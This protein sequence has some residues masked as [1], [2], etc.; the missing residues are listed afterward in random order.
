MSDEEYEAGFLEVFEKAV[1]DRLR[2][3]TGTCGSMLSGG[4]DSGSVV[5]VA[6][7]ILDANGQ[8]R[9]PT[10][11]TAQRPDVDCAESRAIH[12]AVTMPAISPTIIYPDELDNLQEAIASEYDEPFDASSSML[13]AIY[14]TARSHGHRVLLDGG[15]GDLV[16]NDGSYIN[17]LIRQRQVRQAL[18][19]IKGES[20]FWYGASHRRNLVQHFRAA[21]VPFA[22]KRWFQPAR[23]RAY[24]RRSIKESL[25]SR[26]FA[27]HV[28]IPQR[29]A[30]YWDLHARISSENPAVE[31]CDKIL[32]NALAGRERYARLA[33]GADIEARDPFLDRR[34]VEYC[35]RLPGRMLIK[36]GWPKAI[37]RDLMKDRLPDAVRTCRGKPHVGWV[38]NKLVTQ[39]ACDRGELDPAM[40][41]NIL[42]D[43][44][45]PIALD[46]AWQTFRAG[47]DFEPLHMAYS[48]STWLREN[49]NRPVV[50]S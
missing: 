47:E 10:Y 25:V 34:V 30:D 50:S 14:L 39:Q 37:L 48:L 4:L 42:G 21:L 45:D 16:L 11:S 49:V 26:D 9:L 5:A 23:R 24:V 36:N 43:F 31:R 35:A 12:S 13:K 28:R 15:A 8:G 41:R 7:D 20:E 46:E 32:P 40:L 27:D 44:V 3:R 38:F 19:L 29:F 17:R 6:K 18:R 33:A 2:T 1:A 22:V